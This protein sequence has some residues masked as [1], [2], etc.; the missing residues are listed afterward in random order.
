MHRPGSFFIIMGPSGSGKT[1]LVEALFATPGCEQVF[2]VSAYTTRKKRQGEVDGKDFFFVTEERFQQMISSGELLEW[3]RAYQA[4]YGLGKN[5]VSR[6]RAE[7]KTV[8]VVVDRLGA[9]QIKRLIPD[10]IIIMIVAPS[11]DELRYRLEKRSS[12]SSS[13][14]EFRLEQAIREAAQEEQNPLADHVI[15]NDTIAQAV[16]HL[17][18]IVCKGK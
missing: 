1:T 11:L 2:Q 13:T 3:S 12:E 18:E 7:G 14:I 5:E 9:I 4:F 6:A 10:V 16:Q 8:I 17:K 15:I